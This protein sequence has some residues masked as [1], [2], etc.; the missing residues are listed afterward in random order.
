[1]EGAWHLEILR[2]VAAVLPS[3]GGVA[4]HYVTDLAAFL[5]AASRPHIFGVIGYG[6]A[7]FSPLPPACP[8]IAAPIEPA[9]GEAAFEIWTSATP[10]SYVGAGGVTGAV[11][12]EMAFGAVPIAA[13]GMAS[14]EE[15]TEN[16]YLRI[17]EFL[18]Q[19]GFSKPVRFWNYLTEITANELGQ[20]RYRRFNSGRQRA[21]RAKLGQDAPPV[22]SC[23]GG[24]RGRS[25]LYV[26]A[27]RTAAR[28]IENPRQ[29]SAYA[30]PRRYGPT[31]P[32]F[33]RAAMHGPT[34]ADRFFISGTASIVGH[35]TLHAGNFSAQ[36]AETV[37]NLR[38]LID[39]AGE[40]DAR[41]GWAVKAYLRDP[42]NVDAVDAALMALFGTRSQRL[43]LRADICRTDLLLEIEACRL[44]GAKQR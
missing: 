15:E 20:E 9:G 27:A 32:S 35:E 41:Q 25:I 29:V 2:M 43:C 26:L 7:D 10:V 22:A 24:M 36:L 37:T 31:S 14:L 40:D 17:F 5:S 16:A 33:S 19:T 39:L 8:H 44:Q 42:A 38:T 28:P 18:E 30:Y 21:F 13:D 23:L 12:G 3:G 11:S 6:E 34:G 1:L 4:V